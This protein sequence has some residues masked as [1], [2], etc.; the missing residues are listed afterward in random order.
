[1]RCDCLKQ[2]TLYFTLFSNL[3]PCSSSHGYERWLFKAGKH[4]ILPR[5]RICCLARGSRGYEMWL[6]KAGYTVFYLILKTCCLA[7][8]PVDMRCDCLKQVALYFTSFLNLLPCSSSHR[9]EGWS[10]KAGY[11]VFYLILKP[12]ALLELTQIWGVILQSRLHCIL[13]RFW[14][15]CLARPS[16][17]M[18]SD[19]LKQVTL[20]FTSFLNL[21]PCL[22]SHGYERWLFKA[23]YIVF[24]LVLEPAALLELVLIWGVIV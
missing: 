23:G 10:F 16:M 9:Y 21:L 20:Y 3:L 14:T 18:R 22:S 13:P 12:T 15:C 17:D 2:V 19:H 7:R 24:Y 8:A 1:M 6:F 5:S 11:T 4:C